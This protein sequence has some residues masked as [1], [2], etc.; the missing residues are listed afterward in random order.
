LFRDETGD[1]KLEGEELRGLS[2]AAKMNLAGHLHQ[3][4]EREYQFLFHSHSMVDTAKR[5]EADLLTRFVR[6]MADDEFM[7]VMRGLSGMEDINRVYAQ[8]TLYARGNFLLLHSDETALERRRIAYVINLTRQWRPDWGGLLHFA[9][10]EGNVVDTF[11]PHFNSL[12]LFSVPQKHFVSYV[13]PY[14]LGAR[15]A[16]TGWLIAA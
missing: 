10:D 2:P 4:A 6:W 15:A 12:S 11:V 13:A 16:I 7:S 1:R 8:A 14:A 3:L 5:G 9:D